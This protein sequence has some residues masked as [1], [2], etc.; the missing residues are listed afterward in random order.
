MQRPIQI[1]AEFLLLLHQNQLVVQAQ[2]KHGKTI[3][4]NNNAAACA[5]MFE[6]DLHMGAA[7]RCGATAAGFKKENEDHY[8]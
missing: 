7:M 6:G 8:G 5:V 3:A 2:R 1:A 4:E